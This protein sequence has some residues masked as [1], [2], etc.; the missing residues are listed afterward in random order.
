MAYITTRDNLHVHVALCPRTAHGAYVG[1]SESRSTTSGN[2]NQMKY[3]RSCFEQENKRWAHIIGAPQKLD[4]HLSKRL[5]SDRIIFSQRLNHFQMDALLFSARDSPSGL[6]TWT[7]ARIRRM[8]TA[9]PSLSLISSPTRRRSPDSERR[10]FDFLIRR[11]K[12]KPA[13]ESD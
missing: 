8:R 1:C 4:E 2:K 11:L 13:D 7:A 12:P 6:P 10:L 3:L 5:D 9:P